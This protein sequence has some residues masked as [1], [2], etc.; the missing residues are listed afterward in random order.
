M[1]VIND[2]I[3]IITGPTATG[4]THLAVALARE[5]EGEIISA[6]SRQ[7][8]QGMD[9]GTGKDLSEY[10][11]IKYHLIDIASPKEPYH[12]SR[13]LNDFKT[14]LDDILSR[15]K[16]P[17]I[18]GG[19]PM[20]LHALLSG[21]QMQGA[22]PIVSERAQL[23]QLSLQERVD[24][25]KIHFPEV[26]NHFNEWQN[27]V[28]LLRAIEIAQAQKQNLQSVETRHIFKLNQP[29]ILAP[30]Y[31]RLATHKRVAQRLDERLAQGMIEEVKALLSSGI[32]HERLD[33][34]GLEYR[35]I[36]RHLQGLLTFQEMRDQLLIRIRKF[37]KRQDIWFR[38]FER[39]GFGIYWLKEGCFEQAKK[40]TQLYLESEELPK[41]ELTLNEIH[42]PRHVSDLTP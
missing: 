15:K 5:F 27:P 13:F 3:I 32:S 26:A 14:A 41:I 37:V 21:Y 35:Y 17:I 19:T 16:L 28:R 42:Y 8:Y 22:D 36:S 24:F 1:Q 33:F 25:L 10:A 38:K 12:L 40:L 20:W 30:F 34:F 9:L 7:I 29:L 11:E 4:K 31:H 18:C 2:K 6:D 39:D 23:E